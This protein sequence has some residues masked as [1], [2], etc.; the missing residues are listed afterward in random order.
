[1]LII[2]HTTSQ[3]SSLFTTAEIH[4]SSA[5][6]NGN[7]QREKYRLALGNNHMEHDDVS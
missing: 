1:M 6:A 5:K 3:N 4:K 7:S 2:G